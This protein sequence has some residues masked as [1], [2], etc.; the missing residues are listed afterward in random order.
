[1]ADGNDGSNGR[2]TLA[3]AVAEIKHLRVIT[4]AGFK[5]AKDDRAEII[6]VLKDHEGRMREL[7]TKATQNQEQHASM[8]RDG[9]ILSTIQALGALVGGVFIKGGG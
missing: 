7:E 2:I 4:E 3:V 1:M 5:D 6:D 9:A 8:K